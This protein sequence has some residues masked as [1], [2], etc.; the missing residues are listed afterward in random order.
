MPIVAES[1]PLI[2]GATPTPTP[3]PATPTPLPIVTPVPSTPAPA[4]TPTPVT[5]PANFVAR[6]DQFIDRVDSLS[7]CFKR[8]ELTDFSDQEFSDHSQVAMKDRYIAQEKDMFCSMQG[9]NALTKTLR[10]L[11]EE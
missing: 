11:G 10:R 3:R 6:H 8:V 4:L 5:V 9:V 7:A 2:F 1:P